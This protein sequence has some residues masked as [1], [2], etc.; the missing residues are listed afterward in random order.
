MSLYNTLFG[1]HPAADALLSMIDVPRHRIPRF[2]DCF[3]KGDTIV[4]YTR[5]GGG[6]REAFIK[7]NDWLR[8]QTGYITDVDMAF[9]PTYA[10][11]SYAIPAPFRRAC[12]TISETLPNRD[13]S[14]D[15]PRLLAKMADPAMRNDPEVV[16]A[17][18]ASRPIM[19]KIAKGLESGDR[20]TIIDV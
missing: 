9:D 5:T 11:F 13:P 8:I 3:L 19:D 10:L 16:A 17:L 7:E 4:I 2:R 14:V 15:W 12:E 20:H 6:N 1:I 18:A